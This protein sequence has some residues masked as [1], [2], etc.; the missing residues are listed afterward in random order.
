MRR[1]LALMMALGVVWA[2]GCA[3]VE[4]VRS[5]TSWLPRPRLFRGPAGPDVVQV[6]VALLECPPGEA[7]WRY[8]TG[9]LWQMADESFID[10]DR[11]Q[12]M[13]DSGFRAGKVGTQ[14]PA[15]L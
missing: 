1:R 4:A 2:A 13:T 14:P 3:P 7:E 5:S 12:A 10:L 8:L 15:P 9:D 11:R 6:R